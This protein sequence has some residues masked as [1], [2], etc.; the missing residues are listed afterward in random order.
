MSQ[1]LKFTLKGV[2]KSYKMDIEEFKNELIDSA[3]NR[4]TEGPLTQDALKLGLL[5]EFSDRLTQAEEFSDIIPIHFSGTGSQGRKLKID[6]YQRD[7][8]DN[9]I[10]LII[11]DFSGEDS[12][13]SMTRTRAETS[14]KQVQS[15][16]E[17]SISNRIWCDSD[18]GESDG[19][20]LASIISSSQNTVFRYRIYLFTD[21]ALSGRVKDLPEGKIGEVPVEYHIWD[22]TRLATVSASLLGLEEIEIDLTEFVSGGIPCLP[23]SNTDEYRAYLTVIPGDVLAKIYDRYGSK[24]L[25]GNVRSYLTA[26]GKVNKGIQGT[27]RAEPDKFFVYNNGI[28]CTA[29]NAHV[30]SNLE[31]HRLLSV[32][33]LQIVNGGQTTASLHTAFRLGHAD[34]SQIHVQMKLSVVTTDEVEKLEGMIENIARYSNSQNKI[35]EADFFSNHPYHQALERLSRRVSAPA[36][37]GA[38]FN[39]Y[40]FY[41][42]AR[43]QYQNAQLHLTPAKKK[44]FQR[45]HPRSQM[46]V[47]T[48]VAK[49]ENSWMG[50][51]HM[52]SRGAQKNFSDFAEYVTSKWGEDGHHFN[53]DGY[54]RNVVSHAILFRSVEKL[55]S[56]AGW[57]QTGLPRAQIVTYTIAKFAQILNQDHKGA[58]LDFKAIWNAQSLPADLDN[59]LQGL[60]YEV[61]LVI[62]T[63]PVKGIH[64]GEWAKKELCWQQVKALNNHLP[65]KLQNN[66]VNSEE[67]KREQKENAAQGRL[68]SRIDA[69]STVVTLGTGYWEQLGAWASKNSPIYGKEAELVRLASR[70]G[71]IP[72]DRQATILLK[73]REKIE[74]E[75]FRESS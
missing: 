35:S 65:N 9:S 23:A 59:Y 1:F 41:E 31:G 71:W 32:R 22:V 34:L 47:K 64:I 48:D 75:G 39:T 20:E 40:W 3:K 45:L 26:R 17:D 21:S 36:A 54:F 42:R 70:Q 13:D 10:R 25:E 2:L 8:V 15:F 33:Y 7:E 14:F 5:Y 74:R 63:P 55:V 27:I 19:A 66:L 11:C 38:Q 6:G 16:I 73:L 52:V 72:T 43:G 68:D 69:L 37:Q 50:K 30:E 62:T 18:I 12:L 28:T 60:A 58:T 51:P 4:M 56:N 29:T 67:L 24:L 46:F 53:S 57:Y 49:F 61:C 44:E